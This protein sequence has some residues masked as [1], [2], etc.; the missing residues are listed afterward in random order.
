MNR[1]GFHSA[2][3]QTESDIEDQAREKEVA[4]DQSEQCVG[5]R[6]KVRQRAARYGHVRKNDPRRDGHHRKQADECDQHF[7]A[8]NS[9]CAINHCR[10]EEQLNDL[11]AQEHG[12]ESQTNHPRD[13]SESQTR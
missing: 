5:A 8:G 1:R 9:A 7:R 6:A 10:G 2:A 13:S 4:C 11:V 3:E 12:R